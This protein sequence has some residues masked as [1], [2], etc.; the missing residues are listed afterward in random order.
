MADFKFS[1]D[2]E[3]KTTQIDSQINEI[4]SKL[5]NAL[6]DIKV[7]IDLN[8]ASTNISELL[9]ATTNGFQNIQVGVDTRNA[10]N[11]LQNLQERMNN[12]GGNNNNGDGGLQDLADGADEAGA[13]YAELA[14]TAQ[15]AMDAFQ[16]MTEQVFEMNAAQV[17]FQ[18][19]SDLSGASLDNYISKLQ[20]LG[21]TVARTG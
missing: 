21:S 3:L 9:R 19:V 16:A 11:Q 8:T 4:K 18:K 17:E 2:T 20:D 10:E 6:K 15:I 14:Q 5:E 7:N 12:L 1:I 13:S